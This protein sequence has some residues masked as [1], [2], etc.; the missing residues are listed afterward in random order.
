[1]L[2][3]YTTSSDVANKTNTPSMKTYRD[4]RSF[5]RHEFHFSDDACPA[6]RNDFPSSSH[7]NYI[8]S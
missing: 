2:R 1:M 6:L 4:G 8:E 7:Y 3:S 5:Y